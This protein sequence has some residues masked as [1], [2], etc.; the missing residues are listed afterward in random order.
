MARDKSQLF[1]YLNN[2]HIGAEIPESIHLQLI[3]LH[4]EYIIVGGLPAAVASWTTEQSLEKLSKI[5]QNLITTYRDDFGK[6]RGHLDIS[7]LEDVMISVPKQLGHKF[8]YKNVNPDGNTKQIK[9]ALGLLNM[10][11]LTHSVVST[12]AN[13]IPLAAESNKKFFKEISLDVG[14][15]S[16]QMGLTLDKIQ[17]SDEINL[18][19]KGGI[20]EQCTGQLLRTTF[21]Y[22]IDPKLFCWMR[23]DVGTSSEVD[24]I[25]QHKSSVIPVEV[26]AGTTGTLKSLHYF[27]GTKG[28]DF[29]VRVNTDYPSIVDVDMKDTS[30]NRVQ[31]KLMSIPFYLLGQIHR[32]I[33]LAQLG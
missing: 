10:A 13:G 2:F 19:N 28:Y 5:H 23:K 31:Y 12:H 1:D 17:S 18:I 20:A 9:R 24:Y 8:V 3:E 22:Y 32:L 21:P 30:G 27:M 4:K 6:Y 33:D 29:A 16:A 26:K 11:R 7:E 15:C 25:I 14:L